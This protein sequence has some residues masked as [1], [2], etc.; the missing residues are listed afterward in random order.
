M[1]ATIKRI[2]LRLFPAL[3]AGYH[4]PRFARVEALT[5]PQLGGE[6]CTP[7]RPYY[8]VDLQVLTEHGQPDTKIPLLKDVALPTFSAGTQ[9]GIYGK[10]SIGTWVEVA[11]AYGSPNRP[12]IRT[13][14][15]H[16]LQLT[17][18]PEGAQRWQQTKDAYQQIDKHNNNC[19]VNSIDITTTT[20]TT[21]SAGTYN[22]HEHTNT[23]PCKYLP[24]C[25]TAHN[26]V[27]A[28]ALFVSA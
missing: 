26:M 4:L 13:I 2:V 24:S 11:F 3:S 23:I 15:P 1:E 27:E 22:S 12:F 8:A 17:E 7:E 6:Q 16:E 10:P 19:Q 14:L 9:R 25:S 5:E 28:I 18:L 21:R 20:N